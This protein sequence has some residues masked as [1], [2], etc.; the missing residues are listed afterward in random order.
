MGHDGQLTRLA[1]ATLTSSRDTWALTVASLMNR[2]V[3]IS[4]L[5]R[6]RP[7]SA[8]TS[9]SRSVRPASRSRAACRRSGWSSA[10]KWE[11]SRRVTV[12]DSIDAPEATTRTAWTSSRGG[13]SFSRNPAAPAWRAPN[14][15]SSRSKV[16][17]TMT[18][19]AGSRARMAAVAA[20][21]SSRGMRTS[22]STTSGAQRRTASA[23]PAPSSASPTTRRG[24]RPTPGSCAGPPGPAPRRRRSA[25]APRGRRPRDPGDEPPA[26]TICGLGVEPA[27]Q[28]ADPLPQPD[29]ACARARQGGAAGAGG[30]PFS[31]VT[32]T[33]VPSSPVRVTDVGAPGAACARWSAPAPRGRRP[34]RCRPVAP[35]PRP[36]S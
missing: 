11:I 21:P 3:P 28:Q 12:G 17:S 15:W 25:P 13:V 24:R 26:P 1:A 6:P 29:Q 9:D 30:G 10:V 20:I 22:I 4:A 19:G 35:P 18:E 27:A 36:G 31:T 2:A 34:G 14:T 5:D 32:V 16:V 23:A 7:T 33:P 8:S